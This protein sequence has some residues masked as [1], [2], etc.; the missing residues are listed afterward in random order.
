MPAT[1]FLS[2]LDPI[3]TERARRGIEE[4]LVEAS[5]SYQE[6]DRVTSTRAHGYGGIVSSTGYSC[7]PV[8]LKP[9]TPKRKKV[10]SNLS[11]LAEAERK[12]KG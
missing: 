8:P 12:I 6:L 2:T 3:T 7:N 11:V 5:S 1:D 9:V 10:P 4:L